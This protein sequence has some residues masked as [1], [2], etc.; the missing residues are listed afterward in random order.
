[1]TDR[2]ELLAARRTLEQLGYTWHGG[3]LWKP[4][5]GPFPAQQVDILRLSKHDGF[6]THLEPDGGV[7]ITALRNVALRNVR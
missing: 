2:S 7:T 1:M 3:E 4:P 5:L 6:E